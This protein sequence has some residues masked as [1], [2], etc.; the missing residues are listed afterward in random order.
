VF[1]D[2]KL[3]P[4]EPL[5]DAEKTGLVDTAVERIWTSARDL[6]G[7]PDLP[8][9]DGVKLAVQPKEMWMLLLAR[10]ATRGGDLDRKVLST[11]IADDFT[12]R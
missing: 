9:S 10:L 1:A 2:F 7:L 5:E 4:P 6:A 12:V 11:F 3:P 8:I